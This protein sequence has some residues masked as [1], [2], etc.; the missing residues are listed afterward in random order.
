VPEIVVHGENG[1]LVAPA[2]PAD[3]AARVVELLDDTVR[4]LEMGA[5]GRRRVE[6]RFLARTMGD[7]YRSLLAEVVAGA[8]R[9]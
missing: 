6:E 5:E 9:S 8:G 2:D 7:A 1:Y 4:A 3:V